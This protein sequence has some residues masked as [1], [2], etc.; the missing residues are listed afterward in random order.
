M[1]C[2]VYILQSI[3]IDLRIY[4]SI[5]IVIY[6][7]L[8]GIAYLVTPITRGYTLSAIVAPPHTKELKR[9]AQNGQ[10]LEA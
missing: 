9:S 1:Y 5:I 10:L 7:Y 4:T 8:S 3:Y 2:R 6:C